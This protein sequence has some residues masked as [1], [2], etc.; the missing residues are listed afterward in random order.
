MASPTS[1]PSTASRQ[2][3]RST[4]ADWASWP[5]I[6]SRRPAISAFPSSASGS[7]T[8][9]ATSAS[10]SRATGGSKSATPCLT[11]TAV[12]SRCSARAT[13]LPRA[14]PWVFPVD[15]S[16]PLEY[17]LRRWVVSR[18]CSWTPTSRRTDL[19]SARSPTAYTAAAASTGFSRR[20]CWASV[21]FE[22]YA[23]TAGSRA[24]RHR[25]SSTRT[26]VMRDSSASSGSRSSSRRRRP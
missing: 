10:R 2:P 6:T 16:S 8:V 13:V 11:P 26:R 1:P 22:P 3:C 15:V 23:P 25:R 24:E 19:P 5:A 9:P 14:S 12:P 17:G 7:S 4:P 20:C 18:C 21:A